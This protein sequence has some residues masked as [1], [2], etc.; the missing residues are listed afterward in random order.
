MYLF[1]GLDWHSVM[2][3]TLVLTLSSANF[4]LIGELSVGWLLALVRGQLDGLPNVFLF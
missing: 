2:L 3:M 4:V 1:I